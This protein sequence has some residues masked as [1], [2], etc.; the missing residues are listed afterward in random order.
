MVDILIDLQVSDQ[1]IRRYDPLL[2]DSIRK[3]LSK[4]LLKIHNITQAQ[5]DSNLYFY[6][7]DAEKF[8]DLTQKVVEK[9]QELQLEIS[10]E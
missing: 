9:M 1:L 5:L 3:E 2:Q 10:K 6:E 4:S 8:K 7:L